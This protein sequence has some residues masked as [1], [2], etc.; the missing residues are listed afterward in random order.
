MLELH[1]ISLKPEDKL[2]LK[3]LCETRGD[4]IKY[5]EALALIHVN[6]DLND[7]GTPIRPSEGFWILHLP[8]R[9]TFKK[10]RGS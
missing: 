9:S 8:E 10:K 6:K 3:K 4:Q 1:E 2:K 7:D 5:K